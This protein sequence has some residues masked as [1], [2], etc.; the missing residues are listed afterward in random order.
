[1]AQSKRERQ[2]AQRETARAVSDHR[3]NRPNRLAG[4]GNTTRQARMA[5]AEGVMNG[6]IAAPE[7]G[8][9]EAKA[10]GAL[11]S[12]ARWGKAPKGLKRPSAITGITR[13]SNAPRQGQ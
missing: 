11:A 12:K 6:S 7:R 8:T 1:M 9:P 10:L 2:R 3:A 5:Y 4:M 13:M